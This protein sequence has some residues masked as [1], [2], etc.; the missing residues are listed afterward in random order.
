[1]LLSAVSASVVAQSSS[2][3]SEGLMNNPVF[4]G[5]EHVC[6]GISFVI[7]L[8]S[9]HCM[10]VYSECIYCT[11]AL[12]LLYGTVATVFICT[13]KSPVFGAR[14]P[15]RLMAM[16]CA[17]LRFDIKRET[18]LTVRD[19]VS[20]TLLWYR[21]TLSDHHCTGVQ[22]LITAVLRWTGNIN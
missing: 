1:M 10:L 6:A 20:S 16:V 9:A 4:I 13:H 22:L 14:L 17:G 2:E 7:W 18:P 15:R 11:A 8:F 19:H 5:C 3:I 21:T 12:H